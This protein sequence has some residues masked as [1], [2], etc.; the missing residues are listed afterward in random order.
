MHASAHTISSVDPSASQSSST[1]RS[2]EAQRDEFSRRRG[3][4][5]PLAGTLAWGLI[6]LV[7]ALGTPF[8][9]VVTLY[10]ATGSIFYLGMGLSR[11]TGENFFAKGRPKN[12]FD[13]L[14]MAGMLMSLLVFTIAL[15]WASQN[16]ESLPLSFGVL[17]GLMWLPYSW[18]IQHWIGAFHAIA[19]A[20]LCVSAWYAFPAQRFVAIPAVVVAVYLITIAV[21]ER[22]WRALQ[23]R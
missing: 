5:M 6:G 7:G 11:L 22:R 18:I 17:A 3:L 12:E 14:F 21:Q 2:L 1:L 8:Q 10:I 16:Y 20:L 9:A 19:R 13:R 23:A 15:P 4:A